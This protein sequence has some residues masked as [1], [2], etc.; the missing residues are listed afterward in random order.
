MGPFGAWVAHLSQNGIIYQLRVALSF[1]LISTVGIPSVKASVGVTTSPQ[2]HFSM[3]L[4][5]T[6]SLVLNFPVDSLL[7][8]IFSQTI[9]LFLMIIIN[10]KYAFFFFCTDKAI[11][12]WYHQSWLMCVHIPRRSRV[13]IHQR[14]V[15]VLRYPRK[16]AAGRASAWAGAVRWRCLNNS[17]IHVL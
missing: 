16:R 7:V 4:F 12:T 9:F 11:Q 14:Y 5:M 15:L 1:L 8:K 17:M 3:H 13:C 2:W 10:G 6:Y